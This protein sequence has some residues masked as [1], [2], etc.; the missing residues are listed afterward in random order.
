MRVVGGFTAPAWMRP[1]ARAIRWLPLAGAMVLAVVVGGLFFLED[2]GAIP[3]PITWLGLGGLG[4]SVALMLDDPAAA[5]VAPLPTSTGRRVVQRLALVVPATVLIWLL[6]AGLGAVVFDESPS[7]SVG[8][9]LALV[10]IAVAVTSWRMADDPA[11]A[12]TIGA[13]A[14]IALVATGLFGL[15]TGF[16]RTLTESWSTHPWVVVVA[17]GAFTVAVLRRR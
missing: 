16:A 12:T 7:G 1:T 11:T 14:P 13:I 8:G 15:R 6:L 4:A 5:L 9:L 10:G 17:S 3:V 2:A